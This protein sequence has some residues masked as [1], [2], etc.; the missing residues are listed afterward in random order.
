ML[1][2][3]SVR[4]SY[5]HIA[6]EADL[7]S[8]KINVKTTAVAAEKV[9]FSV[10]FIS[11]LM[12]I[13]SYDHLEAHLTTCQSPIGQFFPLRQVWPVFALKVQQQQQQ[14][15][16]GK[17]SRD[18]YTVIKYMIFTLWQQPALLL[19]PARC[20]PKVKYVSLFVHPC[21]VYR[22]FQQQ[23]HPVPLIHLHRRC[24]PLSP[25]FLTSLPPG[26]PFDL[27]KFADEAIFLFF[28]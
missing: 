10:F 8:I 18:Q 1:P 25:P 20:T 21:C 28:K 16:G 27:T 2:S 7:F 11:T 19:L 24:L 17:W 23:P 6:V 22:W 4:C 26:Q 12:T 3:A 9:N 13:S 14:R 15:K 5:F